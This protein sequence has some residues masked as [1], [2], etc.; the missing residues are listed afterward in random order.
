VAD[1]N[2]NDE[3]K[4]RITLASADPELF[5][6][7]KVDFLKQLVE[8]TNKFASINLASGNTLGEELGVAAADALKAGQSLLQRPTVKNALLVADINLKL[9]EIRKNDAETRNLNAEARKKEFDNFKAELEFALLQLTVRA[10][11][12][13]IDD[14]KTVLKQYKIALN[15]MTSKEAIDSP[16]ENIDAPKLTR[17]PQKERRVSKNDRRLEMAPISHPDRRQGQNRRNS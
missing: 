2:N 10:E 5:E 17:Y 9:S 3:G 14:Y 15:K 4:L 11:I 13:D 8:I 1:E 6:K 16:A 12:L 7:L